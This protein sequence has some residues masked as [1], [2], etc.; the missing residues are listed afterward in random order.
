MSRT[1]SVSRSHELRRGRGTG[2]ATP[3]SGG[4]TWVTRP[5]Y[6]GCEARDPFP[7]RAAT[8]MQSHAA[9][10]PVMLSRRALLAS[11]SGLAC[12]LTLGRVTALHAAA[13]KVSG[14]AEAQTAAALENLLVH[15]YDSVLALP[16]S[17]SGAGSAAISHVLSAFRMHHAAHAEMFNT[18]ADTLGGARQTA[19]DGAMDDAVVA[20]ALSTLRGPADVLGLLT[21][22]ESIVAAT[23]VQFSGT[24]GDARALAAL[25]SIAPV[26]AE[27]AALLQTFSALLSAGAPELV[28]LPPDTQA[29]PAAA[30]SAGFA[31]SSLPVSQA[32]R[33]GEEVR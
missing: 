22:V 23:H 29:L 6:E 13:A 2:V 26:E 15:V 18:V 21:N 8:N 10:H 7:A 16:R 30:G 14:R 5:D 1:S 33:A 27:H 11:A 24:A 17:V 3:G 12:A 9:I 32:R 4:A 25:C 20:P 28:A 19:V 31:L